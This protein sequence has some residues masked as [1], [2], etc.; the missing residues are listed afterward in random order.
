M[1]IHFGL[2]ILLY[3]AHDSEVRKA[4]YGETKDY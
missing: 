4:Y 3:F 1:L 2:N